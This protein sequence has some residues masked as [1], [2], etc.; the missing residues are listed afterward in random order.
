MSLVKIEVFSSQF[1]GHVVVGRNGK[2]DTTLRAKVALA[3]RKER[4]DADAIVKGSGHKVEILVRDG[5][6]IGMPSHLEDR[7]KLVEEL[8]AIF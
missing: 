3:F 2:L 7:P 1:G 4:L 5:A 8:S 6:V